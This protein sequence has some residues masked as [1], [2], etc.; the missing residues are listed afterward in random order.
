MSSCLYLKIH[1][2]NLKVVLKFP[3]ALSRSA[4]AGVRPRAA[5][6]R[7]AARIFFLEGCEATKRH[8]TNSVLEG[9]TLAAGW[10]VWLNAAIVEFLCTLVC[11]CVFVCRE[12]IGLNG[13][14]M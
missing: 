12:E 10:K 11:V 2:K 6:C 1:P 3:T 4:A 9:F 14:G 5:F 8:K 13:S 7:R